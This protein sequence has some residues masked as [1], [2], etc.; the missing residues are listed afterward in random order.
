MIFLLLAS[1]YLS[2]NLLHEP[3]SY[4]A[5]ISIGFVLPF[6]SISSILRGY[7]F[8]KQ[9]MWPH[10]IS[11]ITEDFVR[12]ITI[13]IG[14]PIFLMKGINFAVAFIIH[15]PFFSTPNGIK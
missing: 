6:I 9:R 7:F 3:R 14:I 11:N 13:A 5:L 15:S 12:L 1:K 8:G 4:E 10:V 2:N